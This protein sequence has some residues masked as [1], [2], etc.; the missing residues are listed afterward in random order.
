MLQTYIDY[1]ENKLA[2][3][4]SYAKKNKMGFVRSTMKDVVEGMLDLIWENEVGGKSKKNDYVT[5]TSKS[6]AQLKF[7]VDR[8]LYVKN[9]LVALGECK[10]Y[11]DRC[12]MERASSDFNRIKNGVDVKPS[13]FILAL[14]DA[15]GS[16]A[17]R[18]YMDEEHID[19]VFYLCDGKRSPTKPIWKAK[20]YKPLNEEKLEGFVKFIRGFYVK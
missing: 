16:T 9:N 3:A 2:L 11:L 14:E 6:G 1:Y 15:V 10:A 4:S 13:T 20:Y 17:F 8:H 12:F 7:Q 18:Y 5:S 19:N